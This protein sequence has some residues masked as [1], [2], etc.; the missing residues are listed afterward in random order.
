MGTEWSNFITL[1]AARSPQA[2]DIDKVFYLPLAMRLTD[3]TPRQSE[4]HR[5]QGECPR[6]D[7]PRR[8]SA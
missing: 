4:G 5:S 8:E 6:A 1:I 7:P 3:L 2:I